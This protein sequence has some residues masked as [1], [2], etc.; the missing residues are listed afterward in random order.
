MRICAFEHCSN[1][2]YQLEKWNNSPCKLH[3]SKQRDCGCKQPFTLFS[4]PSL[5]KDPETRRE[6][7]KIVNRK[8]PI[9]R[10]IWQPST[11]SRICSDHFIDGK[12]SQA[13]PVPTVKVTLEIPGVVE[14]TTERK[15]R[16]PPK[17]RSHL[18][19]FRVHSSK[20]SRQTKFQKM[21]HLRVILSRQ[22]LQII[23]MH[24]H[25]VLPINAKAVLRRMQSSN[26]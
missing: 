14:A 26:D 13:Y 3:R 19:G 7:V 17:K 20:N 16:A 25:R 1:S 9:T 4:F 8:D 24:Q 22:L 12:P 6:W 21:R 2:T 5:N 18:P 23:V 11:D 15:R 10:K